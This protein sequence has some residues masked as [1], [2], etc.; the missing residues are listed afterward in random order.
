M[1]LPSLLAFEFMPY[2]CDRVSRGDLGLTDW[3]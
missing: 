2:V 1:F 3:I